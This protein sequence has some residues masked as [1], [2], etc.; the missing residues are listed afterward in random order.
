MVQDEIWVE[1]GHLERDVSNSN[2]TILGSFEKSAGLE[3]RLN[4]FIANY[5]AQ[6]QKFEMLGSYYILDVFDFNKSGKVLLLSKDK[7]LIFNNNSKTVKNIKYK[8]E[9]NEIHYS[10]LAIFDELQ[11]KVVTEPEIHEILLKIDSSEDEYQISKDDLINQHPN[12]SFENFI[13]EIVF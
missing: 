4:W 1:L 12:K 9:S 8:I 5:F 10:K 11:D 2:N 6:F 7:G 3:D 13:E